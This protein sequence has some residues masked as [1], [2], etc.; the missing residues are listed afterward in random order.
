M[1]AAA[2]LGRL[3]VKEC[4]AWQKARQQ[5]LRGNFGFGMQTWVKSIYG[6]MLAFV[7]QVFFGIQLPLKLA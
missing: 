5:T 6:A 7:P 3:D 2:Y 4:D 1:T